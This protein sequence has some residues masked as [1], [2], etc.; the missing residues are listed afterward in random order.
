MGLLKLRSQKDISAQVFRFDQG[1]FPLD[2]FLVFES[3]RDA[4]EFIRT[5]AKIEEG[6]EEAIELFALSKK[7]KSV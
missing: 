6:S 4:G 2:P 1:D 5:I 7:A 3:K